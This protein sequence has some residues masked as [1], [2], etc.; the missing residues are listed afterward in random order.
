MNLVQACAGGFE[1]RRIVIDR[2]IGMGL[3]C[4]G[5]GVQDV[6]RRECTLYIYQLSAA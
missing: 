5:V 3:R 1:D 2:W 6:C 4:P